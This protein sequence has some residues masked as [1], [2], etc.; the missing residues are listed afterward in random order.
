MTQATLPFADD[1]PTTVAPYA[2]DRCGFGLGWDHARHGLLPP[3]Q[4][5]L[6]QNPLRQGWEAGRAA[7]GTRT[8]AAT[9]AVQ[10]WLDLRLEAWQHG[11]HFEEIQVTPHYLAQLWV[12]RCPISRRPLQALQG[13]GTAE[14]EHLE[15]A[16]MARLQGEAGYAAGHLAVISLRAAQ[17]MQGRRWDDARLMAV[18]AAARESAAGG[19]APG[20]AGNSDD[21]D[22]L[23]SSEWARL[24]TL[25]SFVTPLPHEVAAAVPLRVLPPNRLRLLNPIQGLQVIITRQIARPGFAARLGQLAALL[26]SPS[27]QRDFHKVVHGLLPRAWDGGRPLTEGQW[28]ERLEDAWADPRLMRCWQRFAL[29]LTAEQAEDLVTQAA[30]KGLVGHT[31]QVQIHAPEQATEGWALESGGYVSR[32]HRSSQQAPARSGFKRLGAKLPYSATTAAAASQ[33]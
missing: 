25:M 31:Q 8:L 13:L 9:P 29:Q 6:P 23:S 4:H 15:P 19:A 30:R 18:L 16:R 28:R 10:A 3:A 11:R 22:A 5:L 12:E 20:P 27:L 14:S 17:A 26:P 7:F 24:A 21:S 2:A 33:A 1:T 32:A